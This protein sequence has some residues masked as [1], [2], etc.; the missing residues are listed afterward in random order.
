M[1]LLP[2][3]LPLLAVAIV[4]AGAWVGLSA[5]AQALIPVDYDRDDEGLIEVSNLAQLNAIRWDLHGDGAADAADDDVPYASA[6]PYAGSDMGCPSAGC[7]GYELNA[8]L[9]FDTNGDGEADPDDDYWN[10]GVGWVPI[11]NFPNPFFGTF[12]GMTT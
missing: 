12:D 5:P 7:T 3:L 4:A 1:G 8:D 6:F 9:D 11:G 10:D 2:W